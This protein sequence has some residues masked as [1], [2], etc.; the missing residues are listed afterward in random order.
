M[1][2]TGHVYTLYRKNSLFDNENIYMLY[3]RT[4]SGD[5]FTD[6]HSICLLHCFPCGFK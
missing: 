6:A 4:D 1:R 3:K 5:M 2:N